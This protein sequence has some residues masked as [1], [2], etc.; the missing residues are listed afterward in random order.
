[1]E[2][3]PWKIDPEAQY[4]AGYEEGALALLREVQPNLPAATL[5]AVQ[6]WLVKLDG[7]RLRSRQEIAKERKPNRVS[8]P[9]LGSN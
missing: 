1:M 6:E 8:P 7:W 3:S 4:R 2:K 9:T 5:Q